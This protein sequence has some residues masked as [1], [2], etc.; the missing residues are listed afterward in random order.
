MTDK[1]AKTVEAKVTA[2]LDDLRAEVDRLTKA[3]ADAKDVFAEDIGVQAESLRKSAENV[4]EDV[5]ERA[6][7]GWREL[8]RQVSDRPVQSA[9]IAL[10]IGFLLSRLLS[11]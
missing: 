2:E 4:A 3:L 5:S 1:A 11:R 7:E 10:G 8:Q 9:L 6:Q